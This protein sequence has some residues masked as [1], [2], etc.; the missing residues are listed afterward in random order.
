MKI[1]GISAFYH[2]SAAAIVEDGKVLFAAQE[3]RFSRVKN[4][5]SFPE[6]A[7][8]FCLYES[9]YNLDDIDV[10]AFYEKP[11]LKFERLLETYYAF[12]PKGF[13][14][15]AKAMPVWLKEKLFIKQLIKK[16]LKEI[17]NFNADAT[18][19]TFTE[20]HLAHAA[21][22]FYTSPFS[23]CAFITVDG[24]GE[25]ATT[26]YGIACGEK[27][28]Q[29][30]GELHFPDSLGLFYSSFT[31]YLGFEVNSGEYKMM[32]LAPY[33]HRSSENVRRFIAL[34]KEALVDIKADGSIKLN[35][36]YFE[37]PVGLRM[38][39]PKK[40]DKLF[41]LTRRKPED[42]LTPEHA[43]LALAAQMVLE[44]ILL[45]IT[46]FVKQQTNE[47][48]LCLAGG[49][50]LNCV[51]NSALYAQHLFNDIFVQPAAGD[52]GGALGAALAVAHI[53]QPLRFKGLEKPFSPY[54]GSK[55]NNNSIKQLLQK[56]KCTYRYFENTDDLTKATAQFIAAKKV[57]GWFRGRTEFGPRALG[58]R[59]IL[60]DASDVAMQHTLNLKIKFREGFRP[61]APAVCEED[62]DTYFEPGKHSDY[63]LFTSTIKQSLRRKLPNTFYNLSLDDRRKFP[64]SDLPAITHIDFSARVQVVKKELNPIFWQLIKSYQ[65]QTEMGVIINTSFNIKDEP[66]VNSAEDAYA[67]FMKTGMD[68]LV[69]ENFIIEK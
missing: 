40:W 28:I 34:I 3:E 60:A 30:L 50:A 33:S 65:Q 66:I 45:K 22:A 19:I 14:S 43:D 51:A 20:H 36:A 62:F 61:F 15:F 44:E 13:R 63:M 37:Y 47:P 64:K 46:Q 7:I 49:V 4:D 18:P 23:K 2:D 32:G 48:N 42:K 24:V 55:S 11:F 1:L 39:N 9:G 26:S 21:S 54:L 8:R 31:Y 12:A 67:C 38:V 59:S 16:R 69:L 56:N 5:P 41:G 6:E 57:V 53:K 35:K 68:V 17:G 27:G 10:I 25:W 29:V 58:N 52:A